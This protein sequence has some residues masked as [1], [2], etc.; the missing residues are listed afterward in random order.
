MDAPPATRPALPRFGVLLALMIGDIM[1]GSLLPAREGGTWVAAVVMVLI[2]TAALV[3]VGLRREGVALF[4]LALASIV[5][6]A[7]ARTTAAT[8]V[9]L[10]ARAVFLSYVEVRIIWRVLGDETVTHDTVSAVACGYVMIGMVWGAFYALLEVLQP[11]SFAI[12][13]AWAAG[14]A[15]DVRALTYFSFITLTSVG[16]GDVLP[17]GSPG[18]GLCI[19]EAIVGQL[20]LAIMIARMVGILAAQR[21]S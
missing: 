1:L 20:Y 14:P 18:G 10:A 15:G 6:E 11:G 8:A 2:L 4:G 9:S 5:V 7:L 19:G 13:A 12:P 3:A 16:F 21:S 17:T